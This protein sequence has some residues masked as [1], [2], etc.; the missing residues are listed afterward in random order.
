MTKYRFRFTCL[1]TGATVVIEE[2][3]DNVPE[4]IAIKATE[5]LIVGVYYEID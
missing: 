4:Y 5:G 1:K 2:I 3:T